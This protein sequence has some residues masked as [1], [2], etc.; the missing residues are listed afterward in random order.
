VLLDCQKEPLREALASAPWLVKINREELEKTTGEACKTESDLIERACGLTNCGAQNVVV[1]T[2]STVWLLSGS[3]TRTYT[4]FG[5]PT[6][7]AMNPTGSGDSMAAGIAF[8]IGKDPS[9]L[10]DPDTLAEAIRLGI[11]CGAAN[12][13]TDSPAKFDAA[14]ASELSRQVEIHTCKNS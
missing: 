7:K 4:K 3:D 13:E 11:G 6:V 1:T 14:R 9:K 10:H 5:G 2:K 8:V 12:A